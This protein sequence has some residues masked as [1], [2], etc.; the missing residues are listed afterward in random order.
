M[1][2]DDPELIEK[3]GELSGA[4]VVE[5]KQSRDPAQCDCA[6]A[7]PPVQA[8]RGRSASD[9]SLDSSLPGPIH[10]RVCAAPLAA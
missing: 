4:S 9:P 7:A 1:W 8:T 3:L 10:E 5:T 2:I 6:V